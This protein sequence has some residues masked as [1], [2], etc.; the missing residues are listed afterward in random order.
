MCP[1][2]NDVYLTESLNLLFA[3]YNALVVLYLHCTQVWYGRLVS[4]IVVCA[5]RL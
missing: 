1:E 2:A 3:T 5:N 4:Y